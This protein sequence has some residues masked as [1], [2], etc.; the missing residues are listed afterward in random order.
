MLSPSKVR[1]AKRRARNLL[2]ESG[3]TAKAALD[4]KKTRVEGTVPNS[5]IIIII[6]Q[7][8]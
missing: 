8:T 7:I 6:L 3:A 5:N 2:A 1:A 4:A